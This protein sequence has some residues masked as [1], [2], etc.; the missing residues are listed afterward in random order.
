MSSPKIIITWVDDE[1]Q[2]TVSEE[3]KKLY[4]MA[5]LDGLQDALVALDKLY[6]EELRNLFA[7]KGKGND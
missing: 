7:P 5:R 2:V 4:G 3:W 6:H 1:A